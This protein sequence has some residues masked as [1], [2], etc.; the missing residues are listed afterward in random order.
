[1]AEVVEA[2]S[3]EP[4][5]SGHRSVWLL[6]GLLFLASVL[7]AGVALSMW[8]PAAFPRLRVLPEPERVVFED[9]CGRGVERFWEE[10]TLFWEHKDFVNAVPC[11]GDGIGDP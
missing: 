1:M 10:G 6:A 5:R 3:M 8:R 2:E 11:P 7:V 4:T 9:S